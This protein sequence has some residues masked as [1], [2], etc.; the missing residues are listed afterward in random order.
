MCGRYSNTRSAQVVRTAFAVDD[1]AAHDWPPRYNIAPG[2][3]VPAIRVMDG[4]RRLELIRWGIV[5]KGWKAGDPRPINAM[6]EKLEGGFWRGAFRARRCVLPAD[7]FYEWQ[8]DTKP[9]QPWRF[10]FA[11]ESPFALG[12]IYESWQPDQGAAVE[13]LAVVT[14]PANKTVAALH[15]R[16]PLILDPVRVD[17][18]LEPDAPPEDLRRLLAPCPAEWLVA[19]TVSPRMNGPAWDDP[20]C[21]EAWS[22]PGDPQ[23]SL[24]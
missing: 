20:A 24:L 23:P 7:G 19:Y 10:A 21:H 4:R 18:W 3:D 14:V 16:M 22:G 9:R 5:R 2:Q 17:R 11:D 8:K 15:D 6:A 13:T 12:A 1:F